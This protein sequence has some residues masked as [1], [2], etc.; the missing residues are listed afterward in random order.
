MAPQPNAF[1]VP[2]PADH[3]H[4]QQQEDYLWGV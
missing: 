2:I 4:D 3:H 1:A